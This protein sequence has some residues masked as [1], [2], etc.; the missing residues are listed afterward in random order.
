MSLIEETNQ[1]YLR[2]GISPVPFLCK[3]LDDCKLGCTKFVEASEPYI[4]R[5]YEKCGHGAMPRLLF[6]S[7]D[8]K[9]P[10]TDPN[11]RT[12]QWHRTYEENEYDHANKNDKHWYWTHELARTLLC[13]FKPSLKREEACWYF[14]HTNSAKCVT[15]NTNN[16]W[17]LFECCREY[18]PGEIEILRPDVLITQGNEARAAIGSLRPTLSDGQDGCGY[19]MIK[20]GDRHVLSFHSIHPAVRNQSF[21]TQTDNCWSRWAVIVGEFWRGK[22]Q[23]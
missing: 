12:I 14:A 10:S 18:I 11:Q 4:G 21:R 8:P 2:Q 23:C 15:D 17:K 19:A 13:Q 1:Y 16:K 6:L 20:T 7:L 3:H 22:S 5:E 9:Y